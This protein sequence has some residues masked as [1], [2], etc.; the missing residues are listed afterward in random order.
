VTKKNC[1]GNMPSGEF[2]GILT[3]FE[4]IK[5][6]ELNLDKNYNDKFKNRYEELRE[7]VS[8]N[9]KVNF[10][11]LSMMNISLG[12]KDI[13]R[14]DNLNIDKN[15]NEFFIYDINKL[16]LDFIDKNYKGYKVRNPLKT[17]KK[18]L[19]EIE[20]NILPLSERDNILYFPS[21]EEAYLF[22]IKPKE[23]F[24]LF[25]TYQYAI[26]QDNIRNPL[27]ASDINKKMIDTLK[28]EPTK[29][30][31]FNNGITAITQ[32][33][34][35]L[36]TKNRNPIIKITG[37]QIINGGQTFKQIY[38]HYK[39]LDI[40]EREILDTNVKILFKI[41]KSTS[42]DFER[43]VTRYTN[44]QNKTDPRDFYSNDYTQKRIQEDFFRN[45][46]I[47]YEIRRGEFIKKRPIG[48]KE[49]ISNE[50]FGQCYMAYKLKIPEKAKSQ[51]SKIFVNN[52]EDGLYENIFNQETKTEDLFI[53][54]IIFDYIIDKEKIYRKKYNLINKKIKAD[55]GYKLDP[56]ESDVIDNDFI[57]HSSF[58]ILMIYRKY[59]DLKGKE[60]GRNLAEDYWYGENKKKKELERIY[61]DIVTE[62]KM[63]IKKKKANPGFTLTKYFK[64]SESTAEIK[65][66][67]N[68]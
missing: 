64:S 34:H 24:S 13:K 35:P 26:F 38:E 31:Y 9:K 2:N 60:Y 14:L 47:W 67:F 29:F 18:P 50:Y 61:E 6:G 40:S 7:H 66:L 45:T 33:I 57:L 16:K 15:F 56:Q 12:T 19:E 48:V 63:F 27:Y 55:E 41:I 28:R 37:I 52:K 21:H 42:E 58:H 43:S 30:W 25:E 22:C 51:T 44:S 36:N 68:L 8:K 39:T 11:I 54:G 23:I 10:I 49:I 5:D 59:F 62:I 4:E 65:M 53:A 46:N 3:E 1:E 20:I 32:N 17:P